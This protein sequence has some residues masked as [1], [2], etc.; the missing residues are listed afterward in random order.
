MAIQEQDSFTQGETVTILAYCKNR[1][2]GVLED[3]T[4]VEYSLE[5]SEGTLQINLQA[6]TKSSTGIYVYYYT[7]ATNAALGKWKSQVKT[8][9]GAGGSAKTTIVPDTFTV[10][11]AQA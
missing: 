11:E 1:D 7:L 4:A 2:T 10:L 8:T 6:M 9:D 5:D 3:P